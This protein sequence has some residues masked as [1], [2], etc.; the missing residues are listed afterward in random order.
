MLMNKEIKM[1]CSS[2]CNGLTGHKSTAHADCN[3]FING[4]PCSCHDSKKCN[5]QHEKNHSPECPLYVEPKFPDSKGW[6]SW[7]DA[8]V[9][10]WISV[11]ENGDEYLNE[12]DIYNLKTH[13]SKHYKEILSQEQG[14]I[15]KDLEGM[16]P[17]HD[18]EFAHD[19]AEQGYNQALSDAINKIKDVKK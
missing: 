2:C 7:I 16:K 6:E 18:F 17:P 1:C 5:C 14:R 10:S 9:N 19:H 8:G 15:I 13:L 4:C 11:A 3:D 12:E